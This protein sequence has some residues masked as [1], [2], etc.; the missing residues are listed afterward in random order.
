MASF[1]TSFL[2]V[3]TLEEARNYMI[4][5]VDQLEEA[6]RACDVIL[7]AAPEIMVEHQQKAYKRWLIKHG[8]AL[9]ALTTLCHT[10]TINEVAYAELRD[11]IMATMNPTMVGSA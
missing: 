4:D 3:K 2:E 6:R 11:R 1:E 5:L 9:G 7:P 10:R 8:Q